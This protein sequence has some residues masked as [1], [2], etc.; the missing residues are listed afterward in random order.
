MAMINGGKL[1]VVTMMAIVLMVAVLGAMFAS[2]FDLDGFLSISMAELVDQE[3]AN[4]EQVNEEPSMLPEPEI[5]EEEEVVEVDELNPEEARQLLGFI[6]YPVLKLQA[7]DV[8]IFSPLV[9]ELMPRLSEEE[10]AERC[11]HFGISF[12]RVSCMRAE[13]A[14]ADSLKS[15]AA[16]RSCMKK[17]GR[18][19]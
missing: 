15:G 12:N 6:D 19:N 18:A 3:Q 10:I 8:S 9:E 4:K 13:T 11:S 5:I 14:C 17:N 1:L 2:T 7:N 16:H